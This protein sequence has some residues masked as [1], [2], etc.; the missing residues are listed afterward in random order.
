MNLKQEQ[1]MPNQEPL[2]ELWI[3][4]VETIKVF[5]DSLR[6]KIL[7]LMEKPTTVKQI[8]SALDLP[9]AKLYYH[10][11]LLV[12]HELIRVVGHN[13]ET[14]IVE[15]IYQVVARNFKLVNPLIAGSDFPTEAAS[16]LFSSM[17]SETAQSFQHA[18]ANRDSSEGHPPRHPF[19]SKKEF[20][21][22]DAQLTALHQ[23]LD[24][25]IQQ[26]T[27]LGTDNATS[28]EPQYELTIVF[29]QKEDLS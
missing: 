2:P 3:R 22:T 8:A 9:P 6:L 19:L 27:A 5:A 14:G 24:A 11:N 29:Y 13:L 12:Q 4:D 10:V 25:L 17:L 18:L 21:L 26:V 28:R 7:R 23:Q 15:K 20:R 1:I 16:A